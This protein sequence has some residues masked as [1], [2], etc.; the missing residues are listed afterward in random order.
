MPREVFNISKAADNVLKKEHIMVVL[1]FNFGHKAAHTK[2]NGG[3]GNYDP[4]N[5]QNFYKLIQ[6]H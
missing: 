3:Q 4:D 2:I 1:T 6:F 5:E